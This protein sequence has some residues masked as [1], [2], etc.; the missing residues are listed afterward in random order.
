MLPHLT[1]FLIG[2]GRK[3]DAWY[4][5]LKVVEVTFDDEPEGFANINTQDELR[6]FM[7]ARRA[8]HHKGA[9]AGAGPGPGWGFGKGDA[10]KPQ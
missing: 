7:V 5:T 3:I 6:S 4:A 1:Q 2:G 9:G 10:P 8:E